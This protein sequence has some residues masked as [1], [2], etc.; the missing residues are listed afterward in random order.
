MCRLCW[1]IFLNVW[2]YKICMSSS[3]IYFRTIYKCLEAKSFSGSVAVWHFE[4]LT[5]IFFQIEKDCYDTA[6][7]YMQV[8]ELPAIVWLFLALVFY[9][10]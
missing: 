8:T 6:K 7:L 1:Y 10:G 5:F 9:L 4:N 3:F 2:R